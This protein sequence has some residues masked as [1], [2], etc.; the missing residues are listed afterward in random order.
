MNRIYQTLVP[1]EYRFW[2][3]KLRHLREFQKLR[4]IVYQSP[5]GN[6]SLRSFDLHSCVFIHIPKSAGTSVAKSLF[7]ELPYHYTATQLRVIFGT[8]TFKRYF[9]FAFVRNPWDRLYSAYSYLKGGGW[10]DQDLSWYIE[11]LADIPDFNSFVMDWLTSKRLQSHIHLKPQSDFI[12]DRHGI[13]LLDFLGYFESIR[14]D[15]ASITEQL[16]M[17]KQLAHVNSSKRKNYRDVYSPDAIEK[18]REL[19]E[20]DIVQFGY[21]FDRVTERKIVQEGRVISE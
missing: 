5:K 15:F 8:R 11:N 10:N 19:Y 16:G 13:A 7:G 12:C 6:F 4:T 17:E 14:E 9:K 3:Y 1:E 2:I 20:N 21:D 18:V